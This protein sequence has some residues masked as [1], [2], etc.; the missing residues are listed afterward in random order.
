MK[1]NSETGYRG[2]E[3]CRGKFRAFFQKGDPNGGHGFNGLARARE[4]IGMYDSAEEAARAVDSYRVRKKGILCAFDQLNLKTEWQ[5]EYDMALAALQEKKRQAADRV[6]EELRNTPIPPESYTML[7]E[8]SR[9]G[10]S[11]ASLAAEF[12]TAEEVVVATLKRLEQERLAQLG[13]NVDVKSD[14]T[15]DS[16]REQVRAAYAAGATLRGLE[17]RFG[18][19]RR[20]ITKWLGLDR[21]K[22]SDAPGEK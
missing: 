12:G 14:A 2:V 8:R 20:T 3:K 9:L 15:Q 13:L 21:G 18:W 7:L 10:V 5:T 16:A 4:T 6:M 11:N 22:V 19:D 17:R 1:I